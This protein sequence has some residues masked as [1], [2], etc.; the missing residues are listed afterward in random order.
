M[1]NS[2]ASSAGKPAD[3]RHSRRFAC[4]FDITI[5]WGAAVLAGS[6]KEISAGGMFVE[7]EAPLWIGAR[8][9]AQLALDKPVALDCVVCRV[10]PHRGMAVTFAASPEVGRARIT[11]LLQRLA[12]G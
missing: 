11:V 7:L 2:M 12:A 10:E 1:S 5:E 9:A 6:V 4:D 3:R 8:F